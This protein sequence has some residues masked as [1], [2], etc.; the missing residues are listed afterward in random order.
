MGTLSP[1]ARS[2]GSNVGMGLC[3]RPCGRYLSS[4]PDN[5][6]NVPLVIRF[7]LSNLLVLG[8]HLNGPLAFGVWKE[9]GDAGSVLEAP[10]LG[11]FGFR[12][13]RIS[14]PIFSSAHTDR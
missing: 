14:P 9:V 7:N 10:A 1:M 6:L 2:L 4:C 5:H 8:I 3:L 11:P 13:S 12:F